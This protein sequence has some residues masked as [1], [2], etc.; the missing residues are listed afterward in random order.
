MHTY[1]REPGIP[2]T[3]MHRKLHLG[4][5]CRASELATA[6]TRFDLGPAT[7]SLCEAV[8]LSLTSGWLRSLLAIS[9]A[10]RSW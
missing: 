2:G 7:G 1:S 4:L 6:F 8:S 3:R 5:Q 9:D 10:T